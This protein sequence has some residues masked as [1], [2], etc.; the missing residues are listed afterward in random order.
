M[1]SSSLSAL[2]GLRIVSFESRRASEMAELLRRYGAE[3]VIAPSM[4]E[5]PLSENTAALDFV[6][7]LEAGEVDMVI[8][9]TGVGTRTLVEA[10]TGHYPKEKLAQLLGRVTLVARGPKPV[11]ALR[12]LGLQPNISVPEPN[13]WR[14]ILS[15]IDSKTAVRGKRIAI[16]EYG[17]TN[18]ELVQALRARG[19]EVERVPVYRWDLPEDTSPLRSAIGE[20][21]AGKIDIALFTNA[22]QIDHILRVARQDHIEPPLRESLARIVVASIGPVCTEVLEH[23]GLKPDLEPKHPKMGHLVAAVAERGPMLLDQ[24]RQLGA[25]N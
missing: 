19:A 24:K 11:A 10:V 2:R 1:E 6:K 18:S 16:Q 20:L 12:E 7:R 13:T 4:R 9:L 8:L 25:K 22:T 14:E 15:Q 5:I 3:P 23:F 17:I 21:V